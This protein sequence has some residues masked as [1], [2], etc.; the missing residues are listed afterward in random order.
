[1]NR[2][3]YHQTRH[4]IAGRSPVKQGASVLSGHLFGLAIMLALCLLVLPGLGDG[5]AA[6]RPIDQDQFFKDIQALSAVQ[7]RSTGT[8]G[9][10]G[11]RLH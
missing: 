3:Q 5:I 4:K 9:N 1:M 2:K 7:D 8:S 6:T 10:K 11:C